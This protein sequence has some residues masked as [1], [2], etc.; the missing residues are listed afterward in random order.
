M[1]SDR[2]SWALSQAFL[3]PS[4]RFILVILCSH[5]DEHGAC[6]PSIEY[7]GQLSGL[8][9]SSVMRTIKRLCTLKLLHKISHKNAFLDK[10]V[11]SYMI[12]CVGN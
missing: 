12:N 9:K 2:I 4:E 7:L 1:L 8:S 6:Y 11:N 3:S 10:R 5:A